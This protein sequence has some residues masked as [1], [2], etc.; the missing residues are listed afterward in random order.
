MSEENASPRFEKRVKGN[1]L[2]SFNSN[3]YIVA[4]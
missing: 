4:F 1:D 3:P 2:S